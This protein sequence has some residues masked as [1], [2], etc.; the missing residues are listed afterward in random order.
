MK[1]PVHLLVPFH[2]IGA[3]KVSPVVLPDELFEK[4]GTDVDPLGREQKVLHGRIGV[5]AVLDTG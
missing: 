3:E 2:E 5:M 1:N 4:V